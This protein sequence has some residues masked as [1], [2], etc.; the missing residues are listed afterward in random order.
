MAGDPLHNPALKSICFILELLSVFAVTAA[1]AA[2]LLH[3]RAAVFAV[4]AAAAAATPASFQDIP[5][6]IAAAKAEKSER[7]AVQADMRDPDN[8]DT[9]VVLY[10]QVLQDMLMLPKVKH[11]CMSSVSTH[12]FWHCCSMCGFLHLHVDCT[13]LPAAIVRTGAVL[14]N[15]FE[16][17]NI[18]AS[19]VFALLPRLVQHAHTALL[20]LPPGPWRE[21]EGNQRLQAHRAEHCVR[22][23][24]PAVFHPVLHSALSQCATARGSKG[25]SAG[26]RTATSCSV[27]HTSSG[28]DA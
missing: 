26:R 2:Y 16:G 27:A 10:L 12:S 17:Y 15:W 19:T 28:W 4:T 3:S 6:I 13:R 8:P 22:H 9:G 7:L 25:G 14:W 18:S 21:G 24:D 11:G 23:Q 20:L 1:A 5:S